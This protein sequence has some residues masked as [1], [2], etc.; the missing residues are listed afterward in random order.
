MT[1]PVCRWFAACRQPATL[2]VEHPT[3]GWVPICDQHLEWLS[4]QPNGGPKWVPP[5]VAKHFRRIQAA[6]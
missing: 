6:S 1:A 5:I 4:D 2:D 3:L